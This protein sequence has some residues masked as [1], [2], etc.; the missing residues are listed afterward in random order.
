MVKHLC[1]N[2]NVDLILLQEHWL[3]LDSYVLN[4]ISISF[5][6]FSVSGMLSELSTNNL[7]GRPFGGIASMVR[8]S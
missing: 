7:K 5:T 8:N 6:C 3:H 2:L 1:D 4:S